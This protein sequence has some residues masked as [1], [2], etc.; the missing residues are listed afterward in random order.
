MVEFDETEAKRSQFSFFTTNHNQ[1]ISLSLYIYTS[2]GLK[3]KRPT[4]DHH[5]TSRWWIMGADGSSRTGYCRCRSLDMLSDEEGDI[6]DIPA[7]FDD[8][9]GRDCGE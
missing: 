3:I 9:A 8:M 2:S 1:S 6:H 7:T 5:P 4:R